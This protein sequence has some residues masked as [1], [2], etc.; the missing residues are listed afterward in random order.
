MNNEKSFGFNGIIL[1][2]YEDFWNLIG[3]EFLTMLERSRVKG[4]LL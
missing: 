3:W 4:Y 1:D 2:F